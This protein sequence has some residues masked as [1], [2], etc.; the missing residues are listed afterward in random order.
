MRNSVEVSLGFV[1]G[2]AQH[3]H[4]VQIVIPVAGNLIQLPLCHKRGLGEQVAALLLLILYPALQ[5]LNDPRALGQQNGQALTNHVHGGEVFQLPAKLVVVALSGL[6]LLLQEGVQFFLLGEGD[7]VN[8]LQHFPFAVPTPVRAAGAG[9]L[10]GVA[11]DAAGGIQMRAGAKIGKFP[12]GV[13]GNYRVLR[14]IVDK[15]YLVGFV[16]FL[17]IG[18]CFGAGLFRALQMQPLLAD[19][20]HFGFNLGKMLRG[21]G[22]GRVKIV[23]PAFFNGGT[24][25]Q[26]R[27]GVQ[28]LYRLRHDVG[29]GVPVGFAIFGIFKGVD[30]FFRH[31]NCSF[32]AT[33]E[34]AAYPWSALGANLYVRPAIPF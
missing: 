16:L 10:K 13:E 30:G 20:L 4:T 24:N 6:L 25:G 33:L 7:A 21:K 18:D 32:P 11:L 31:K 28:P 12:L 27:L 1:L 17:H 34:I 23:V 19:F 9:K 15:L 22:K 8:S 3:E 26:L 29:A 14:Q 5:K 2:I